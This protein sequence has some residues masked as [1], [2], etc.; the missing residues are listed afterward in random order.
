MLVVCI[1][2]GAVM[3]AWNEKL[4]KEN[5]VNPGQNMVTFM[6]DPA[7]DLARACGM[8]MDAGSDEAG[9]LGRSK[10]YALHIQNNIIKYEAV[11]ESEGDPA[12]NL[13]PSVT[14][15]DAMLQAILVKREQQVA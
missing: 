8:L 14:S 15:Y 7:G 6:G 11:S 10:R 9:M 12:G 5:N 4:L 13:D 1:N 2:D 3:R